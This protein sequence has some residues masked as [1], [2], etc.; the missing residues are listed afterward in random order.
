MTVLPAGL[1]TVTVARDLGEA[2]ATDGKPCVRWR[3]KRLHPELA[4]SGC[5]MRR[6]LL[7]DS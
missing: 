4:A 3:S 2:L 1:S 5:G 7:C 6:S